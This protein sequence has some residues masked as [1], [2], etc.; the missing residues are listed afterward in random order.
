[1]D[2]PDHGRIGADRV[3]P[4]LIALTGRAIRLFAGGGRGSWLGARWRVL[5]AVS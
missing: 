1:V 3:V 2:F 4:R 5:G